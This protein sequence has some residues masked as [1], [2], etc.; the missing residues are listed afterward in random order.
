M[1]RS[2]RRRCQRVAH[3]GG[4]ALAPENTLA[5]FGQARQWPVDAIELDVQM[6]RDGYLIV[7]HDHTVQRLTEARGNLL[8]LELAELQTLD[9]ARHFP[10]G[11]PQRERIPL[12]CDVLQL[13]QAA[14]L[15][16][17]IEI[18]Q[19]ERAGVPVCYPGI[20]E[21]VVQEVRAA[22]MLE[23]VLIISFD[24]DALGRIKAL[25]PALPTGALV[26]ASTWSPRT[27][28]AFPALMERIRPWQCEWIG[29]QDSLVT[30]Q[31]PDVCHAQGFLLGVW[32]V[33]EL[34]R[35]QDLARAGVDALTS[36][37]PDL[38]RLLP[39]ELLWHA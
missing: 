21:A 9:A 29:I 34:D 35:L 31:M 17:H 14:E 32:T 25:E 13:A 26:A 38:F 37:R 4:A 33:N 15:Q 39:E 12:L 27:A 6:S 16:V 18:K 20:A 30:P 1:E 36:D 19:G 24:W 11:W 10:G 22:E 28:D 23:Q 8:D 5:A 3:R 7:F 2:A